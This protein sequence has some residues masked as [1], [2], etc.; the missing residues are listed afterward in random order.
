MI[1]RKPL[2]AGEGHST[3]IGRSQGLACLFVSSEHKKSDRVSVRVVEVDGDKDREYK[4]IVNITRRQITFGIRRYFKCGC[5]HLVNT[6]YL[7]SGDFA[8]RHCHNLV[9]EIT[10]LK[11]GTLAYRLNRHMKVQAMEHQVRNITYRDVY[12]RKARQVMAMING[13]CR[14]TS[15]WI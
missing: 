15:Q 7:K 4:D 13:R 8:C 11:K 2:E 12:T 3:L 9:Y 1:P 10:R 6:L 14:S 5:G